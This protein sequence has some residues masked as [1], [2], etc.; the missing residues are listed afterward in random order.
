MA[1][2][3]AGDVAGEVASESGGERGS[4][5][6]AAAAIEGAAM[7]RSAAAR[8]VDMGTSVAVGRA[9]ES[10]GSPY[11]AIERFPRVPVEPASDA[12][13]RSRLRR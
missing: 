9:T 11:T 2:E 13:S 3:M 10:R 1:G 12:T 8:D 5:G 7:V 4:G 6:E